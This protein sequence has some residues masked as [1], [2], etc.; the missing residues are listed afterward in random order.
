MAR[1]D[2]LDQGHRA[3]IANQEIFFVATA[4]S[5]GRVSLAPDTLR[6]LGR[7][8]IAWL[9]LTGAENEIA[10]SGRSVAHD[11]HVMLVGCGLGRSPT[12]PSERLNPR[13]SCDRERRR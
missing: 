13:S 3:F 7:S 4:A 11:H 9:D 2:G 5:R 1:F 10:A 12:E 6:M 8:R